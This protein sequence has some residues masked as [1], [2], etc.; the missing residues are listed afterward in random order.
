MQIPKEMMPSVADI[1]CCQLSS[2]QTEW[3]GAEMIVGCNL[4]S[5]DREERSSE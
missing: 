1:G 2:R 4:V 5:L 3:A